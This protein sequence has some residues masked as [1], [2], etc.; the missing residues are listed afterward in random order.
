MKQFNVKTKQALTAIQWESRFALFSNYIDQVP[1][2]KGKPSSAA[3]LSYEI[4]TPNRLKMGRNN[5]RS[6]GIKTEILD[7]VVPSKILDQNRKITEAFYKLLM[8]RIHEL[9][10]KPEKWSKSS[11][12]K[13][14]VN[15]IVMF[16]LGD[17][18]VSEDW[19]LG[20]IINVRERSASVL[21]IKKTEVGKAPTIGILD[22]PIRKISIIYADGEIDLNTDEHRRKILETRQ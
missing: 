13:L 1:I 21:Y 10:L 12:R 16:Q 14:E 19:R 3:D 2:A 22:R 5:M 17:G 6:I 7:P 15:D 18:D 8:E 11:E 4:L 20:R 9:V